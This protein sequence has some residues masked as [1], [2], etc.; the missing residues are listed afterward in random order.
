[1][2]KPSYT[3]KDMIAI[4]LAVFFAFVLIFVGMCLE[5][6][7]SFVSSKNPIAA[8]GKGLNFK[9]IECG[10]SGF[11]CLVLV[12]LYVAVFA[13]V[14]LY[15]RRFAIVTNKKVYGIKMI[16]TYVLSFLACGVISVG[17]GILIQKPL[18]WDNISLVLQKSEL[19]NVSIKENILW[20]NQ[21]ATME[22]VIEASK[23]AQA[24]DFIM[25]KPSGFDEIVEQKGAS[26][27]G[28]QKQRLSIARAIIKKPEIIIFDDS[29]SALDLVTEAKLYNALN[30]Y[31][32]DTTKIVVAQRIA[33]AKNA[34][35]IIVLDNAKVVAFDTHENLMRDCLIYQD[36]YNSQLKR[37]GE[38]NE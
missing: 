14:F 28:G 26:L 32:K 21:D 4:S 19:F 20:G 9:V 15:E 34:D 13:A 5:G 6:T 24:Y 2:K 1:M 31:L 17:V 33:T 27:S 36:I 3:R 30:D 35:K 10:I 25:E 23:I 7:Y 38:D 37:E 12:A 18:T 11:I 16:L 29:T 22:E 8:I